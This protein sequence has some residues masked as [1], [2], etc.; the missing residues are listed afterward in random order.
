[1][2]DFIPSQITAGVTL[3]VLLTLTCH[4][5]PDW[6]VS[7]IMRK[8]G[9]GS[10][11]VVNGSAEGTQH[12]LRKESAVTATWA[13]AVYSYVLRA[14]SAS[15]VVDVESGTLTIKPDLATISD[16]NFDPRNH[17][18]KVLS[19]IEAT[20]EGRAS[21]DQER[22]VINNR[23]LWRTP[24]ADLLKLRSF[25]LEELR[26]EEAAA[27]SGGSLLGRNVKVRF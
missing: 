11:I 2:S 16:S 25:Y 15:D 7:L 8:A 24:I 5:A 9:A 17:V 27:R 10:A 18:R 22:Y 19:A 21:K 20:I 13:P 26:R 1:M 23:E 12:R 14:T 4:P 6:S 3:D